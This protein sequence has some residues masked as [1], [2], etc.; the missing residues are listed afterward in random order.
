MV[1]ITNKQ[2]EEY[3]QLKSDRDNHRIL[4]PDGLRFMCRANKGD[5]TEIG[6]CLLECLEHIDKMEQMDKKLKI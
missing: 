6:K 5:P 3:Q 2:Y 1:K 4:T